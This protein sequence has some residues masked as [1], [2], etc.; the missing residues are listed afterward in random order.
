MGG[1]VPVPV[2]AVTGEGGV[3]VPVG[4]TMEDDAKHKEMSLKALCVIERPPVF[5]R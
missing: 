5:P 2:P 4:N 3:P 1:T